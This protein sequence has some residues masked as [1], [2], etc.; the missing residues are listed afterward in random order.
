MSRFIIELVALSC[1][2][3]GMVSVVLILH[4]VIAL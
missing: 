3:M 1:W 4:G 2:L